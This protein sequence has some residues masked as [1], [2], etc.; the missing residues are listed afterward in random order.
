MP[1][2]DQLELT[3]KELKEELT[4][5]LTAD[6][7]HAPQN[8][9]RYNFKESTFK[10][11]SLPT[12]VESLLHWFVISADLYTLFHGYFYSLSWPTGG[13]ASCVLHV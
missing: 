11:V 5:V 8:V 3:E 9:V 6:N 4:R 12:F 10:Q 2:E 13:V 7:P 1:P